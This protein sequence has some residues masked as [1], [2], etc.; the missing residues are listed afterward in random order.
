MFHFKETCPICS[1]VHSKELLSE[2]ISVGGWGNLHVQHS[3]GNYLCI[4]KITTACQ[5]QAFIGTAHR[6]CSHR[7][8]TL[9]AEG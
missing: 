7:K 5:S 3:K 4:S 1:T 2:G 9:A 8:P 6:N